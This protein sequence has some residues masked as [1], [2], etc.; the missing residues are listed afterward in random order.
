MINVLIADDHAIIRRGLKQILSEDPGI[1]VKDEVANGHQVLEKLRQNRYDILI[2]DI[3]M[4][5]LSG[6]DVLL[7]VKVEFP[8]LPV[9][10]LSIYPEDQYA[11]RVL[12]DGASGYMNKEVAPDELIKAVKKIIKGKKYISENIA[13]HLVA[14]IG[15]GDGE[16]L[17][18]K[19]SD[20]EFTVFRL[21]AE[22]KVNKEIAAELNLSA[23]T[24]STYRTRIL[25]KM[26]LKNNAQLISYAV[27][28][29]LVD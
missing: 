19:L 29:K 11:I 22:G 20:R 2:M 9:L 27:R 23:K 24:I 16:K 8:E 3:S 14:M 6:L 15:D 21:I 17:Q 25:E 26:N 5:K 1:A 7:Q 4:P 12:K 18:E 10:I 13:E 28:E